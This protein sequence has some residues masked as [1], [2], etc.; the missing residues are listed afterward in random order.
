VARFA[1]ALS[2]MLTFA[3]CVHAETPLRASLPL[4]LGVD[5]RFGST[6]GTPFAIGVRP[7]LL[8]AFAD[9]RFAAG[10]YG[11]AVAEHGGSSLLGGGASAVAY[12]GSFGLALSAGADRRSGAGTARVSPT[13]GGFFGLRASHSE[14]TDN[15]WP[16]ELPFGLRVDARPGSS[17]APTSLAV[18]LQLDVGGALAF[19]A[20]LAAHPEFGH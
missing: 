19:F 15:G 5:H 12:F 18:Q 8:L 17:G 1:C 14:M 7:E 6:P 11:D 3:P 4:L 2:G 20:Y 16:L 13:L 10:A 9:N